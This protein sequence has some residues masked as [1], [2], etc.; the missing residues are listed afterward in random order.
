MSLKQLFLLNKLRRTFDNADDS[1]NGEL[2]WR[3][4][5]G[6][7]VSGRLTA[8]RAGHTMIV[9]RPHTQPDVGH[10]L[11]A[12]EAQ[13]TEDRQQEQQDAAGFDVGPNH[14]PSDLLHEVI[15][16]RVVSVLSMFGTVYHIQL[17]SLIWLL[18]KG[19]LLILIY[20]IFLRFFLSNFFFTA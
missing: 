1:V 18:S 16:L 12:D 3:G 2:L 13:M 9:V 7:G 4:H 5:L 19:P 17:I 6:G 10:R 11:R 14:L 8:P 20:L 15:I